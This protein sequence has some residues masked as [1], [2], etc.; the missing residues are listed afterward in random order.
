MIRNL[1]LST[2]TLLLTVSATAQEKWS[3]R[4]CID[5]A[6]DHNIAIRQ[7]ALSV[8][9]AEIDLNSARNSRLPGL[10]ASVTENFNFG[11]SQ[12]MGTGAYE[13]NLSSV[14]TSTNVG[15]S[16]SATLFSGMRIA[17]Q[18]DANELN[19]QAAVAGLAR[20][21]ENLG[22]TVA[23]YYLDVLFQKEILTVA[24]EQAK[25]TESQVE[26]T[27]I[28]VQEGKV[29]ESQLFD[30]QAQ[31]A[32]NQVA[33]TNARNS[34]ALSLLNLAQ[35]LNLTDDADFDVRE[36]T[37]GPITVPFIMALGV[38]LAAMRGGKDASS[39]SFGLV[40]L[41][42][43]G[44]ILAVMLM[45]IFYNP[46]DAAYTAVQIP[47]ADEAKALAA[48]QT[49]GPVL[50]NNQ[51]TMSRVL[52]QKMAP[53]SIGI[54]QIVLSY[55]QTA[56]ADSL[57]T[58]LK[59][60]GDFAAAAAQYSQND[61]TAGAGGEVGVYPFS[62]FSGDFI[63]ALGDA[64]TGDIVKIASG[65]AIQLL[66]VYRADK[67]SQHMQIATI[68]YPVEA[69]TATRNT[70]NTQAAKFQSAA[71]GSV[72]AFNDA[73]AQ[74]SVTPRVAGIAQGDRT[75][76]GMEDS[77]EIVRW[78]NG[79]KKGALSEIFQSDGNYVVA[80]LTDIDDNDYASVEKVAP[81]IKTQL[82]RDKKYDAIASKIQGTSLEEKA[83]SLGV[84][85]TGFANVNYGGFYIDSVGVEPRL[86]GAITTTPEKG[87]VSAPVKGLSGVYVFRVDDIQTTDK[88]T[89]EGEK[90][91]AQAT[92]ESM[93]QQYAAP[94]IQQMAHIEDLRGQYF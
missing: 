57:L 6:L 68:T 75:I 87:V 85:V 39:D 7:Q 72:E 52:E 74:A 51:W 40:A 58:A 56:L 47:D 18:I 17:N 16:A 76:R 25:L 26:K 34:R 12:N 37:T 84:P 80:L 22:L 15:M 24:E 91:R 19:L 29:P 45:G 14:S 61:A 78:V 41:C 8:E 64:K 71:R 42:S 83:A 53:D 94:A 13:T 27:R 50:K 81:Q 93:V 59:A 33:V 44:P 90:A 30:I 73:A 62:A 31:L 55:T 10:S 20:A 89:A 92:T 35:A 1:I 49:Y 88:Q 23:S 46:Q 65:N 3:L 69:S 2:A 82:I 11:R 86:I 28:L 54:R 67:P 60:G 9:S 66:Q 43:V 5:Y 79:A 70:I 38:G 4:R 77:R 36:V 63:A 21:R 48:G 32:Q